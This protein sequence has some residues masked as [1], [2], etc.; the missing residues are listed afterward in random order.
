MSTHPEEVGTIKFLQHS[1]RVNSSRL[2]LCDQ[3]YLSE[4]RESILVE[5]RSGECP[6]CGVL[7]PVAPLL[8]VKL[9]WRSVSVSGETYCRNSGNNIDWYCFS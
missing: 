2:G 8:V 1:G 9:S 6:K 7:G 3:Q 5:S 4:L